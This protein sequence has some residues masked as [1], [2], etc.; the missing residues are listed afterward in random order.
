[1]MRSL[2]HD[3]SQRHCG[4]FSRSVA[5]LSVIL[6]LEDDADRIRRFTKALRSV[7]ASSSLKIWR[8]AY[9]MS[10][11]VE[12]F[13][14]VAQLIS[15]DH[16]LE[17]GPGD[18]PDLGDGIIAAKA[19]VS[20]RQPCPVIIHSSNGTRSGWMAG[21]FELA[22][23]TYRRVA[24]IGERWIEEYWRIVVRDLLQKTKA[25]SDQESVKGHFRGFM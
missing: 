12:A 8:D 1:M 18:P 9:V 25:K 2:G 6:M 17:P 16:D 20:H 23:W 5:G 7:D 13:F 11:E 14:P 4:R 10:R 24:P 22:G 3:Q 15:L 21:E 19:L